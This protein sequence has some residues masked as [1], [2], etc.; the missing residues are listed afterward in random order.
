MPQLCE[1]PSALDALW[2]LV[3]PRDTA[4]FVANALSLVL[5]MVL[6]FALY[7]L[8]ACCARRKYESRRRT[9]HVDDLMW[10]Q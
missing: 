1:G 4:D 9:F 8:V 10:L 2:T 6:V 3:K 7:R 5:F